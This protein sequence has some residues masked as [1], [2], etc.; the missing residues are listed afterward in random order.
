MDDGL[1]TIA[2]TQV[3]GWTCACTGTARHETKKGRVG[4]A[5]GPW[6]HSMWK[7][8]VQQGTLLVALANEEFFCFQAVTWLMRAS[9]SLTAGHAETTTKTQGMFLIEKSAG[10]SFATG[11]ST[12]ADG[13]KV[14]CQYAALAIAKVIEILFVLPTQGMFSCR[15]VVSRNLRFHCDKTQACC[16]C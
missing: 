8:A 2:T 10:M 12:C 5:A 3:K 6:R 16:M 1:Q 7:L 9:L 13:K 11:H 15:S 4:L 14:L